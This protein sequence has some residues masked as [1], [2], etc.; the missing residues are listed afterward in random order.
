MTRSYVYKLRMPRL[1]S[2]FLAVF[3]L[4][5]CSEKDDSKY[6]MPKFPVVTETSFEIISDEIEGVNAISDLWGNDKYLFLIA[7]DFFSEKFF[8]CFD[9]A[10]GRY[11]MSSVSSGRGPGETMLG[12]TLTTL[13]GPTMYM[14]DRVK[15]STIYFNTDSIVANGASAIREQGTV[16]DDWCV[17]Y[18]EIPDGRILEVSMPTYMKIDS[19]GV[20]NRITV[21]KE[22]GDPESSFDEYPDLDKKVLYNVYFQAKYTVCGDRLAVG[23]S[24]GGILETFELG[25][26]R[27]KQLGRGQFIKPVFDEK[28]GFK[29]PRCFSDL[30]ATPKY[31]YGSFDGKLREKGVEYDD[32][33]YSRIVVFDWRCRPVKQIQTDYSIQRIYVADEHTLYAVVED[34]LSA[35]YLARLAI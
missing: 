18:S 32:M 12:Q 34:S 1:W 4:T 16:F 15:N 3:F 9:I 29:C 19:L 31:I 26:G 6:E 13:Q 14:H 30:Y 7:Y 10:D 28:E 11:I 24:L 21:Y 33:K 35:T 8:H 20:H 17:F 5:A 25:G 23:T 22:N 2:L 27:I